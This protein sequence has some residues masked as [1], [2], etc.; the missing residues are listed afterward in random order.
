MAFCKKNSPPEGQGAHT[1]CR[2][3]GGKGCPGNGG[4]VDAPGHP[5][6][7]WLIYS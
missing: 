2:T 5:A 1:I 7:R 4:G 6:G 3:V